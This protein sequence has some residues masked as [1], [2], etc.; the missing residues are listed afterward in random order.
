MPGA[1]DGDPGAGVALAPAQVGRVAEGGAGRIQFRH[2]RV[3]GAVV[4]R[5]EGPGGGGEVR[6]G[7]VGVARDVGAARVVDRDPEEAEVSQI[8][9]PIALHE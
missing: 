8:H 3:E 2:E 9:S 4:A 5:V 7:G 1:I 6:R